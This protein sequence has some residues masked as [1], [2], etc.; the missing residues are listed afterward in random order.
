MLTHSNRVGSPLFQR[1]V[2][3][4]T[5]ARSRFPSR[6]KEAGAVFRERAILFMKDLDLFTSLCIARLVLW[7]RTRRRH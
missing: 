4:A 3:T 6:V 1:L 7:R 2:L 5:T